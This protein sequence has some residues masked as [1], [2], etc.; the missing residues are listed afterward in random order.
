MIKHIVHRDEIESPIPEGQSAIEIAAH[1][2][3]L[4]QGLTSELEGERRE[5]KPDDPSWRQAV[6]HFQVPAR[7]TSEVKPARM[8]CETMADKHR[9]A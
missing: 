9:S 1:Q 8:G 2:V 3:R 6:E 4:R 7:A 5:V